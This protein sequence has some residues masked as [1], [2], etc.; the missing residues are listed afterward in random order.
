MNKEPNLEIKIVARTDQPTIKF[1]VVRQHR[2]LRS[3]KANRITSYKGWTLYSASHP[4][5]CLH[6]KFL[7][8]RGE[9]NSKDRKYSK[10]VTCKSFAERDKVLGTIQK[11]VKKVNE[12]E[13]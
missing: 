5:I 11:L 13:L 6:S 2:K 9:H 7:W 12:M 1:K 8:I 4:E 10:E 3:P